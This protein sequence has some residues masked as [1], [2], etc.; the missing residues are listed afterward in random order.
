MSRAGR[1]IAANQTGRVFQLLAFVQEH[2]DEH[3][4][5][6]T[7]E[8]IMGGIGLAS[9]SVAWRLVSVAVGAGF[10][11]KTPE[12]ARSIRLTSEGRLLVRSKDPGMAHR[13]A[14]DVPVRVHGGKGSAGMNL[15]GPAGGT[16]GRRLQIV[17]IMLRGDTSPALLAAEVGV[18]IAVIKSDI[19]AMTA[20]LPVY[21][22]AGRVG[23]TP[24]DLQDW[25]RRL[26]G[27]PITLPARGEAAAR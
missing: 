21:E 6:P 25:M 5:A 17:G 23:I 3:G 24:E 9:K 7:L 1:G 14:W 19:S 11:V 22:E 13:L 12:I 15:V 20:S 8:E 10:A 2:Q 16:V 18:S 26:Y 4:Y 27:W